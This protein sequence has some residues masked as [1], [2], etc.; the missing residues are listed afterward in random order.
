[1]ACR[2][3]DTDTDTLVNYSPLTKEEVHSLCILQY[4]GIMTNSLNDYRFTRKIQLS[5]YFFRKWKYVLERLCFLR[6]R[7][8]YKCTSI[9]SI[10]RIQRKQRMAMLYRS[11][12]HIPQMNALRDTIYRPNEYNEITARRGCG[13]FP[14]YLYRPPVIT[15]SSTETLADA[16]SSENEGFTVQESY[17]PAE[18]VDLE[19]FTNESVCSDPDICSDTG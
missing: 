11:D 13:R 18:F 3:T 4:L 10:T 1:M 17:D 12:F 16:H 6:T 14:Y 19:S 7:W 8:L 2:H 15:F 9:A 5:N